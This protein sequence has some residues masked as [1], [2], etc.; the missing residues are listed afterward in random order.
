VQPRILAVLIACSVASAAAFPLRA[1]TAADL[2]KLIADAAKYESGQN[3]EPIQKIEQILRD[4]AGKPALRAELEAAA[5]KLLAPTATFEARR[6]ACQILAVVGTDASLPALAEL[7]KSDETA[8]IACLALSDR[9]SLKANEVLRNFLPSARGGVRLQ[10][11]GALGNHR[12][13]LSVKALAE[14][15]RDADA[16]VA[17]TAILALGKIGSTAAHDAVAALR[18]E[19]RP[20]QARAVTE[21]TLRVAEQLAAAGDRKAASAIYAELLQP[22]TPANIRRGALAAQMQLDKDG[23]QQRILETLGGRDATLIPVAIARVASLKSEGAS[24]TFAAML[25]RLSPSARVWMIEALASRG[26]A[27]ARAA[28]RAEVS[29]TDAGVRRA[30]ILAVGKLDDASAVGLLVKLLAGGKSPEELQDIEIA[31]T[32]LRGGVATDQALVA[33]LKQCSADAKIRLFSVLAR[34]G[35]RAAVPALLAETGGSDSAT[36]RAAFQSLGKLA[37]AD[38]LP[39]LLERLVS[40]KA[41][42]AR[43]DA[44]RAAGRALA[45]IADVARRSETVRAT[46]AKSSDAEARCSLLR[47]LPSAADASALAVL[48]AGCGDKE[49]RIRDAAVRA[50]A[51]WPDAT[52]WNA[53]LAVVRRPESDTHRALALRAMVRLAADLNAK[54]DAGLIERYRQLLSGARGD[55]DRKLILGALAGAAHPDALQLALPLLSSSGVRAEAELAVKKIAASVRA[56]HPQ[57]AQAALERLKQAKP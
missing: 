23:G 5:V 55:D 22:E 13:A 44:E 32:S 12:D 1:E 40:V 27:A 11:I 2:P 49:P 20:A 28:V 39:A 56:Q 35:A 50:L 48:E 26:D 30:A 4:S 34:R 19:A 54:P 25:P 53:L 52:G 17:E 33:E 15:T 24:Q 51:A 37:A 9:C 8:G 46:L 16:A 36:V 6:F 45:K 7:L 18:K 41:A 29:A 43:A 42:D 47:L 21:A 38:D 14:L 10:I 3:A 57:A 31:L